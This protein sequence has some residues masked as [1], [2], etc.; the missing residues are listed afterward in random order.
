[1][2]TEKSQGY[3]AAF[4]DVC[5]YISTGDLVQDHTTFNVC[6]LAAMGNVEGCLS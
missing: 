3:L 6:P 1:V 5:N 2:N 4:N